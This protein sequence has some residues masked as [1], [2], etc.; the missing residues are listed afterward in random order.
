[1]GEITITVEEYKSLLETSV[2]VG[3]FIDFV[4]GER[5]SIG[6]EECGRYLGFEVENRDGDD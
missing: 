2:R 6:R 4:K 3:M 1:M 5:F